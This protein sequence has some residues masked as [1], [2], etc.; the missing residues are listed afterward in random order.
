MPRPRPSDL[1]TIV[2]RTEL[3]QESS[4][5]SNTA[6]LSDAEQGNEPSSVV[7]QLTEP[8]MGYGPKQTRATAPPLMGGLPVHMEDDAEEDSYYAH[9]PNQKH[10]GGTDA[11]GV[12]PV[13]KPRRWLFVAFVVLL[14]VAAGIAV[15]AGVAVSSESSSS[16]SSVVGPTPAPAAG[17]GPSHSPTFMTMQ[18][19]VPGPSIVP[20]VPPTTSTL[21][22][23]SS[24]SSPTMEFVLPPIGG[25]V[26]DNCPPPR[27]D[28]VPSPADEPSVLLGL[29]LVRWR[30]LREGPP[31]VLEPG[32]TTLD[33]EVSMT[34]QC[35][36]NGEIYLYSGDD[37]ETQDNQVHCSGNRAAVVI[38]CFGG[39][40]ENAN[41]ITQVNEVA[42]T[43]P[44]GNREF[45]SQITISCY[46]GWDRSFSCIG[47]SVLG[48]DIWNNNSIPLC[49][50]ETECDSGPCLVN[51]AGAQTDYPSQSSY[52]LQETRLFK[53]EGESCENDWECE[54]RIC[55]KAL[56]RRGP[57]C[58]GA[59]CDEH[60]HCA[61]LD[62]TPLGCVGGFCEAVSQ[63]D[64]AVL[65]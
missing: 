22:P 57:G 38:G 60:H 48:N 16:G 28:P 25:I 64:G 11:V 20:T 47:S 33:Q 2:E 29:Y 19:G 6:A 40:T 58:L 1:S 37:C 42:R 5:V 35:T 34:A 59:E 14:I 10:Q 43:C 63:D 27:P 12:P 13:K 56:C 49:E 15:A 39:S 26:G 45:K 17:G 65:P 4:R 18:P 23:T 32:T 55:A 52:C 51:G 24:T 30:I 54:S 9:D 61:Q 44:G 62:S 50:I 46:P 36:N 21:F 31:C 7:S 41:L 8:S 3:S 53:G